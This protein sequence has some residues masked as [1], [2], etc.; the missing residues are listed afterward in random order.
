MRLTIERMRTLVLSAGILLIVAMVVFLA[1]G[2]WKSPFSGRDLPHKL[3]IDIRQ[4]ANGWTYTHELRGHTL[5]K[6]HANKLIQLKQSNHV[7][8]RGVKIELYGADGSRVD[9]IEGN[10]FEYDPTG[11]IAK[12]NGPVELT[13]M[14]PSVAPAI[15]PKATPDQIVGDK[16]KNSTL[17]A[18]AQTAASGEIHVKTSGLTFD[19]NSGV[20]ST[21]QRVEFDM[22]QGNGSAMGASYASQQG[23]L[24]LNQTV[25]LRS[26]RGGEPIILHAQHAEFQRETL[27]CSLRTATVEY[28]KGTATAGETKILF[29]SDGSAIRLDATNGLAFTTATGSHMAAPRGSL[30]FGDRNQPKHGH[31]EGG[32]TVD[33]TSQTAKGNRQLHGNAPTAEL[34]FTPQGELRLAHLERGVTLDSTENSMSQAMPLRVRRNWRSPV[35]DVEFRRSKQGKTEPATMRGTGG[36]V[37]TS[38]SQRGKEA[39]A[40][41]KLAADTVT[42]TFGPGSE[43][44][45]M[46][47][48]GHASMEETTASGTRQKT[49]GDRLEAHFAFEPGTRSGQGGAMQIQ[50]ATVNGHVVLMEEPAAKPG[51]ATAAAL[52]ATAG[53]AVYEG[54]GEW[55]HLTQSPRVENG[56][57][58]LTANKIDVS[59]ISGDAFAHGNVKASWVETGAEKANRTRNRQPSGG[60]AMGGQG[61]VHA[62]AAEAQLHKENGEATFRGHARIWQQ[63]NSLSAPV[64]VLDR[65]KQTLAAR[66]TSAAEPV[67]TVMVSAAAKAAA[68]K[69]SQPSVIRVRGGDFKYSD[70]E[71]KATMHGSAAGSVVAETGTATSVSNEVEMVLLPP[72]NHAGKDGAAAQVDRMTAR[73]RV[74]V[75]SQGRRG[76]GEQLA[77]SSENGEYVL[78]GTTAAPPRMID[79]ARGTVTGEALIFSSRDD[80]VSVEGGGRKTTTDTR[81]PR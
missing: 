26:E 49:S 9:R 44:T 6:I 14:R 33:S 43:L 42:G 22:T 3:G 35:T 68:N 2:K 4:E 72:G 12:A 79:P 77:Y 73:G 15:A 57:L 19:Q 65:V 30:D 27:I 63:A 17:A 31:M 1:I 40:P 59:Q 69:P 61:P 71:R 64:I 29:R 54:T 58:Q 53:R 36:V 62:I 18:A 37:V 81:A 28:H 76:T 55:L 24:T 16:A 70:A 7:L 67:R 34:Q 48:I 5:Y 10:E 75:S 46:T 47:G 45:A 39:A 78:T 51:G 13:L 50:S 25:E 8:L 20:A 11:G 32:V 80:S 56:G 41:T 60:T 74:T 66:C 23:L 52:H 21:S 38:E